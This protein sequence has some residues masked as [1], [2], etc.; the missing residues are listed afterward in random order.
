MGETLH[1]TGHSE[2]AR[3]QHA[4]AL[5]LAV[6]TGDRYQQARAHSGLAHTRHA[7]GEQGLAR[8]HWQHAL[9]LY[10][11]LGVPDAD[12]VRADLAALGHIA[13]DSGAG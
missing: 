8:Q 13:E 11:D 10:T 6:E 3:A 2:Q 7:A 9:T 5:A 4:A 1:A 12:D